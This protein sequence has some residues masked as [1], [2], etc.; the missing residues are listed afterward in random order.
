[1]MDFC[2]GQLKL[3]SSVTETTVDW[4]WYPYIPFGK[5]TLIQGDPGCG[6]ST[7]MMNLIASV[8]NGS[9]SID[10]KTNRKPM[11][12]IYQ[13]SEDGLS[14]TIKPRLIA[15]GA[16]CSNIA[17]LDEEKEQFSLS[18]DTIRRTSRKCVLYDCR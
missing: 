11:H 12:V 6:K 4:L 5:I 2:S 7:L 16:N 1:M 14:D 9:F 15:A 3:Y 8:S 17:F 18:D 10:R 13:C